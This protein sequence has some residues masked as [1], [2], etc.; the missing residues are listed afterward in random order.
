MNNYQ[1]LLK[2]TSERRVELFHSIVLWKNFHLFKENHQD[3]L[4]HEI[5]SILFLGVNA[6]NLLGL[7]LKSDFLSF[8]KNV[9]NQI[10]R[11]HV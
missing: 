11:A 9:S 4:K 3:L 8:Q 2:L 6:P 10:G 1:Q 5:N 7:L